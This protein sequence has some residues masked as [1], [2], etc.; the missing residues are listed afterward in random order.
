MGMITIAL[1]T[2]HKLPG[3]ASTGGT[4]SLSAAIATL[5]H[6]TGDITQSRQHDAPLHRA[7]CGNVVFW[8]ICWAVA[9]GSGD[10]PGACIRK[11][12]TVKM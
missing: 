1:I 4:A 5:G 3:I 9:S 12:E 10:R 7:C 6:G 11:Q 8:E 2:V